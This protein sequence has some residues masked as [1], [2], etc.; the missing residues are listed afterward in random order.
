[1]AGGELYYDD[2]KSGCAIFVG[3]FSHGSMDKGVVYTGTEAKYSMEQGRWNGDIN[4]SIVE[5]F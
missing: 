2:D 4:P 1:M 3:D 5:E